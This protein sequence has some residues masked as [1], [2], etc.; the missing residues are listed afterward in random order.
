MKNLLDIDVV[1]YY[2]YTLTLC[3]SQTAS[4]S[5]SKPIFDPKLMYMGS[6]LGKVKLFWEILYIQLFAIFSS[7]I[8]KEWVIYS[9]HGP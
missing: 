2:Y 6:Y 8:F 3:R 7:V 1:F 4:F 5:H 9:R